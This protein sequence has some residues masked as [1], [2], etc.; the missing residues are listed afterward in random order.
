MVLRQS[1]ALTW[2]SYL[3][4]HMWLCVCCRN[5]SPG[6]AWFLQLD[7]RFP[8]DPSRRLRQWG[9]NPS[10]TWLQCQRTWYEEG[11][12]YL[13]GRKCPEEKRFYLL[14]EQ[15]VE[16]FG[17]VVLFVFNLRL[18]QFDGDVRI[19]LPVNVGWVQICGLPQT[20][21]NTSNKRK[22]SPREE[23]LNVLELT[24]MTY[25]RTRTLMGSLLGMFWN[26]PMLES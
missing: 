24:L 19:S 26:I 20:Y 9:W 21:K 11:A 13:R 6:P 18:S 2:R 5:G 14:A 22:S 3:W 10:G 8:P 16:L 12:F 25:T 17:D 23:V 1:F 7:H 15:R 4:Y